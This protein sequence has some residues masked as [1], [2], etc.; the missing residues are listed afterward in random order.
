MKRKE[1]DSSAKVQ[2][3]LVDLTDG[4]SVCELIYGDLDFWQRLLSQGRRKFQ[5]YHAELDKVIIKVFYK[6]TMETIKALADEYDEY[7]EGED[8]TDL[9]HCIAM[10]LR[11]LDQE[12]VFIIQ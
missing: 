5:F 7:R 3:D 11:Y 12:V 2:I 9:A 1:C 10:M 8:L 4:S 6:Y